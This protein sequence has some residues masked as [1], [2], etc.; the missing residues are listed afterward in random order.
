MVYATMKDKF[1]KQRMN[2]SDFHGFCF[3]STS[4]CVLVFLVPFLN[5]KKLDTTITFLFLLSVWLWT[6]TK[7]MR[8]IMF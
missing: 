6:K 8:K 1:F 2:Q 3:I 5:A 7:Q 4:L